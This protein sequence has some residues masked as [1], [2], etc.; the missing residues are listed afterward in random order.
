M[1]AGSTVQG[2]ATELPTEVVSDLRTRLRRAAGQ[3]SAVETMLAD[4]REG[5]DIAAKLRASRSA[6]EQVGFRLLASGLTYC[7]EHPES[8]AQS[9]YPLEEVQRMFT[10]LA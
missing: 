3:V 6:L 1:R 10:R 4:G 7:L 2:G 8:A 9:R 5:R